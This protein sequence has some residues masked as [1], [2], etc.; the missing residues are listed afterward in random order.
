[1]SLVDNIAVVGGSLAGFRAVEELRHQGYE[2]RLTVV[3]AEP[4]LPYDRPPL[5]KQIL[6]GAWERDRLALMPIGKDIADLD[7]EWRL[8]V[9]ARSLDVAGHTVEL[10][11][12]ERVPFDGLII[13]TGAPGRTLPGQPEP[14]APPPSRTAD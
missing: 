6:A 12:D 3:G 13:A 11:N 2:G 5:S 1:P 10:A 4:H 9:A 14:G 8:G 7:V